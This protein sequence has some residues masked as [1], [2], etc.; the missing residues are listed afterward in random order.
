MRHTINIVQNQ[1]GVSIVVLRGGQVRRYRQ[2]TLSSLTRCR[3]LLRSNL[4][5]ATALRLNEPAT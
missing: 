2:P 4:R 3:R 5:A 1:R